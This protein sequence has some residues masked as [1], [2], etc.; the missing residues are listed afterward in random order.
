M[1]TECPPPRSC[2][3]TSQVWLNLPPGVSVHAAGNATMDACVS[4]GFDGGVGGADPFL[5][6]AASDCCLFTVPVKVRNCPAG[7][8]NV[9]YLGPTQACPMAY[10][11]APAQPVTGAAPALRLEPPEVL[12]QSRDGRTLLRCKTNCPECR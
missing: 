11:A 5:A 7:G 10:C 3:T 8:F 1:A 2:G 9:Y 4:W 12:T 6:P